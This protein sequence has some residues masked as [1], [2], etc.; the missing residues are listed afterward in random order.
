[1]PVMRFP[2]GYALHVRV[3]E[4]PYIKTNAHL[5]SNKDLAPIDG[6]LARAHKE[7]N[8]CYY[9]PG[10]GSDCTLEVAGTFACCGDSFACTVGGEQCACA[11]NGNT[12]ISQT[13]KYQLQVDFLISRDIEKFKRVDYW[14]FAAPACAVNLNGHAVFEKY[15]ADN[16]CFNDTHSLYDGGGSLFHQ[17]IEDDINPYVKTKISVVAPA[18]GNIVFAQGHF[19]T[20][21]I[22][23]TLLLDG[24]VICSAGAVYGTDS[25][26]ATNARNEQNH[27]VLI[28]SCYTEIGQTGVRFDAGAV[29][30]TESFYYGGT[31]DER[32]VGIGAAGEHKNVMSMFGVG[33][34]FDGDA[35]YLTKKRTSF[36][37]WNNF[38]PI[39]G[40]KRKPNPK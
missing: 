38:V 6:S 13:T 17:I 12:N 10:K 36:A 9:A 24:D 27:L 40:Y 5:L 37:H 23:A 15:P 4:M 22:N 25:N 33:V 39:A 29:L 21:G 26:E 35:D 31:D 11:T 1:M 16:Y 14:Q 19:H 3:N 7:C 20:G 18:G 28:E 2:D 32:F 8:E 34:V 30:T